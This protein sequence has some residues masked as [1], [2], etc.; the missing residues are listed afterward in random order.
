M[1]YPF[2]LQIKR[3]T[4]L[5]QVYEQLWPRIQSFL[6]NPDAPINYQL[7][8]L[9]VIDSSGTRIIKDLE[10]PEASLLLDERQ[11]P[12]LSIDWNPDVF[13]ANYDEKRALV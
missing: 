4:T 12:M 11:T 9:K 7:F 5:A 1:G 2:M 8:S 13:G 10:D 3:S 6:R